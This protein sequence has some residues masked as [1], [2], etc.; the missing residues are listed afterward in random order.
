MI[1]GYDMDELLREIE[2]V[3]S[4]LC[5]AFQLKMSERPD[6]KDKPTA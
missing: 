2:F 6:T 1:A 3:I 5:E 4:D